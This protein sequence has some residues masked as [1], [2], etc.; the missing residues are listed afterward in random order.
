M[1]WLTS[2]GVC[3]MLG[4]TVLY[5]GLPA[6]W[7]PAILSAAGAVLLAQDGWPSLLVW[8]ALLAWLALICGPRWRHPALVTKLGLAGLLLA[9]ALYQ[10]A[11]AW[12][13]LAAYLGFAFV[14]LKAWHLIAEHGHDA[15][16]Q[17]RMLTSLCYLLF[18]P[19]IAIGPVQRFAVFRVELLRARWDSAL[20]SRSLERILYGY[21][22][23]I[24]LAYYL[25][26]SKLNGLQGMSGNLALDIYL[27]WLAYGLDLYWQFSGYCDIAIGFAGLLGM[28]VP[29]NF[30]SPFAARSLPDFWRRWHI[31]VSEWCRDFVFRPVFSRSQRY[32]YAS[33]CS[34]VV[35]GL[36]HELSPRYLVWGAFHGLG[37][38]LA[39]LWSTHMPLAARLRE[40]LAWRGACQFVTL[41]FVIVS[42]AFTSN[43]SVGQALH[44]FGILAG[45]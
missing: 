17:G 30:N 11:K 14:M 6:R 37:L 40:S 45:Q 26:G 38:A 32:L 3:F 25:L 22:K 24:L 5:W 42:F 7:R 36:W 9:F 1:V 15:V 27:G 12:H 28:R 41:Q 13:A 35:L 23:V 4:V 29:E 19:T 10:Y 16:R 34:M 20:A 39:H 2:F 33:L 18:P 44:Q 21:C 43:P 8:C 31:T